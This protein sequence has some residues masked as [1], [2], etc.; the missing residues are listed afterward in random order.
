MDYGEEMKALSRRFE[1]VRGCPRPILK[2][3]KPKRKKLVARCAHCGAERRSEPTEGLEPWV[4]GPAP[5]TGEQRDL[6][7]K[8]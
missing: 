3:Y 5:T 2:A 7:S 6:F 1:K 4:S 8:R